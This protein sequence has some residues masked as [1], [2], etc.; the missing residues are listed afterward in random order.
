M[1]SPWLRRLVCLLGLALVGT[2]L[3]FVYDLWPNWFT[4][5]FAPVNESIW[6]H[7]KLLYWPLLGL[8]LA[9]CWQDESARSDA[10]QALL[11]AC[12]TLLV[13]GYGYHNLL[14]QDGLWFDLIL[15]YA[16]LA[17]GFYKPK[18]LRPFPRWN[19]FFWL[20]LALGVAV[21][22]LTWHPLPYAIFRSPG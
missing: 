16:L 20:T 10:C 19:G 3:H 21:L 15:Y 14:G 8:A 1:K 6:E 18:S 17:W 2:G 13:V 11:L 7:L 12:G 22:W 4:A 5:L 9:T